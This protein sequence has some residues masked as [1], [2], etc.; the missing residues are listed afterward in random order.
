MA[1]VNV[2]VSL[3]EVDD[4][5]LIEELE[6]RGYAIMQDVEEADSNESIRIIYEL[7]RLGKDYQRELDVLIY[8]TIGRI[9]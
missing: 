1:W 7:R 9:A 5:D 2:E 6:D 3:D 4:S 8:K